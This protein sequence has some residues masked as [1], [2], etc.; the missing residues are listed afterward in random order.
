MS[1]FQVTVVILLRI[2]TYDFFLIYHLILKT[3][4]THLFVRFRLLKSE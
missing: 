4:W 2:V 1:F 3:T